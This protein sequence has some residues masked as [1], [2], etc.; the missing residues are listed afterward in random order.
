M[1]SMQPEA[2]P[3]SISTFFLLAL[4]H[5]D[6]HLLPQVN[7]LKDKNLIVR[8][9]SLLAARDLLASPIDY[10]QCIAAGITPAVIRLLKV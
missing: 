9:K 2:P 4:I 7:E 3:K 8:Q 10:M 1:E 6:I 5:V